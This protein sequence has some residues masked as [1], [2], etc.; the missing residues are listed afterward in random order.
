VRRKEGGRAGKR[1]GMEGRRNLSEGGRIEEEV[2]SG[3]WQA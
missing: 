2:C 1:M 3:L